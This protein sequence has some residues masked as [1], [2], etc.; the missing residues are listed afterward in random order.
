MNRTL[1]FWPYFAAAPRA[2]LVVKE[3]AADEHESLNHR[4]RDSA[5]A[6]ADGAI[7]NGE[8]TMI[9]RVETRIPRDLRGQ[10]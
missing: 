7:S 3:R 5:T 1:C 2:T 9:N 6:V 8:K 4:A 10:Y